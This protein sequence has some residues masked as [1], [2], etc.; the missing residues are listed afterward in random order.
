METLPRQ[1]YPYAPPA[2]ILRTQSGASDRREARQTGGRAG[3][4]PLGG[5]AERPEKGIRMK[6]RFKAYKAY[7]PV[8]PGVFVNSMR[9]GCV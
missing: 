2:V 3:P 6:S 9:T 8:G 1:A 5:G 7:M 4:I